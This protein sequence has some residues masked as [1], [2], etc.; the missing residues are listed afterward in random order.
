[1]YFDTTPEAE[2]ND[3]EVTIPTVTLDGELTIEEL[4][5]VL[6]RMEEHVK[7]FDNGRA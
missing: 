5:T 1:M 6:T 4:K 3:G 7:E 2:N